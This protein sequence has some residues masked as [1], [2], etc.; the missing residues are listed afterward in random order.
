MRP[1]WSLRALIRAGVVAASACPCFAQ[2]LTG[3][4]VGTVSDEQ[5]APLTAASLTLTGKTGSWGA[6]PDPRG[7]YRFPAVEPGRYELRAEAPR[8]QP[9]IER[10]IALS[11]GERLNFDF[12]L[13]LAPVLESVEVEG[14]SPVVDVHSS[15][16]HTGLAQS[17]LLQVPL[18]RF[19]PTL[20]DATPGINGG[21]SG[22][23]SGNAARGSS[24]FGS[25]EVGNA[26]L[27][28][29][30]D[31]RDP[32]DQGKWL[33]IGYNT[34]EEVQVLGPGAPAEYGVFTGAVM[35]AVRRSGG[36]RLEGLL[37][38]RATW[39]GLS[40]DNVDAALTAQ[41]P[42]L[43]NPGVTTGL[44]DL[45]AQVAGPIRKDRLF[46]F[47][48][49]QRAEHERDPSGPRSSAD[50]LDYRLDAKLTW[51]PGPRDHVSAGLF[52]N[53][54]DITGQPGVP[55]GVATDELT[56]RWHK[57]DW[58]WHAQ[59][60]RSFG[61]RTL[62]EARY[63]GWT[64]VVE[65]E[66][67][68]AAPR[69]Q[70]L[71]T[72]S[73]SGGAGAFGRF[74]R[75]RDQ[76]NASLS[77]YAEGFLGA[78]D[79]KF[80]IEIERGTGR[81]ALS[82]VGGYG[83]LD[84]AGQPYLAFSFSY[85]FTGKP[86]RESLYAQDAWRAAERLTLNVGVRLD[87]YR[88]EGLSESVYQAKGLA[89]RLGL[90]YDLTGDRRTVLKASFGRYYEALPASYFTDALAG[91]EDSVLY[92][93]TGPR[94]VEI[95][96]VRAS[97][98][99]RVDPEIRH[100]HLDELAAGC[101]RAFGGHLRLSATGLWRRSK[102]FV[103]VVVPDARFRPVQ[104]PNL[105]TGAPMTVYAW[106]NPSVVGADRLV[107][108]PDGFAYLSTDERPLGNAP[109][110]RDYKGLVLILS[111]RLVGRW[112]AQA[113]YVLS[114]VEGSVDNDYF[115]SLGAP[116]PF[117]S[118]TRALVNAEGLPTH[119]ARHE[120]KLLGSYQV[121]K[122][123]LALSGFF[124]AVG[125]T[126]Y[127]PFQYL[128]GL[129]APFLESVRLESRGS[130]RLPTLVQLDVRIEKVFAIGRGL[131]VYLDI[132]NVFNAS[133]AVSAQARVP[134][135]AVPG[136]ETPVAFGAPAAILPARQAIVA[137]RFSF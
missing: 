15:S 40:S 56:Y 102:D 133:T 9:R 10:E 31:T 16:T 78:H 67:A 81:N 107:T 111:R 122:I 47:L 96:R 45:N 84:Y 117:L 76:A 115:E 73:Y 58:S 120:F 71:A 137:A 37:E 46:F 13:G 124:R 26:L 131:G 88:G 82:L 108:N 2:S 27:V 43:A 92:D 19:V 94:P 118:A 79:F 112:Q 49:G 28:D 60:R 97:V 62:V 126:T 50:T 24:A 91:T 64:G 100:L 68:A 6:T 85:D 114:R 93:N 63:L 54:A 116:G 11:M 35:N 59:W 38:S 39:E 83:F 134:D 44:L 128:P 7:R 89:P 12:A 33:T 90:A 104:V 48:S 5:G 129:P 136:L 8:F 106:A 65:L 127:T 72:G 20:L 34:L 87:N 51:Q 21:S 53:R 119:D 123:E 30:V 32:G 29:G 57:P 86:E 1:K 105:L 74:E 132:I 17:F 80:G 113:S 52:Y 41:N 110:F 125:G 130:R 69:R 18:T 77:H 70:D 98:P 61:A 99:A 25:G 4:I 14:A 3:S 42:A 103:G 121:P 22:F 95:A 135:A 66:P 36:N 109:A 101:E 75:R 55:E 23:T